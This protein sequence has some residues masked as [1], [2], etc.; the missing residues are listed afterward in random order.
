MI[1]TGDDGVKHKIA[2]FKENGNGRKIDQYL[3]VI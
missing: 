2:L 3:V 1:K